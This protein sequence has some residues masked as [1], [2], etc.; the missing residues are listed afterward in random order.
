MLNAIE[1]KQKWY[2]LLEI[3]KKTNLL[4]VRNGVFGKRQNYTKREHLTL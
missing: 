1:L 3:Q 4:S 2:F